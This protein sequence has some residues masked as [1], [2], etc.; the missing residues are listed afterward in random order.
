M[1]GDT[2]GFSFPVEP[3]QSPLVCAGSLSSAWTQLSLVVPS[4]LLGC[5]VFGEVF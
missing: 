3:L 5:L 1:R 4:I 2:R